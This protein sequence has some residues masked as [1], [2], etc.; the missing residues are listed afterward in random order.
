MNDRVNS[1]VWRGSRRVV[2][3]AR[4]LS[5][6]VQPPLMA[7]MTSSRSSRR[8][9]RIGIVIVIIMV[10]GVGALLCCCYRLQVCMRIQAHSWSRAQYNGHDA[11]QASSGVQAALG[12]HPQPVQGV[13]SQ[14][15]QF[16]VA[17]R[18]E[19]VSCLEQICAC[20]YVCDFMCVSEFHKVAFMRGNNVC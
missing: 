17:T 20:I 19:Q 10:I 7:P 9:F 4:R 14:D 16:N 5:P 18:V 13:V 1:L 8:N 2:T 6:H 3:M 15:G 11:P 12:A